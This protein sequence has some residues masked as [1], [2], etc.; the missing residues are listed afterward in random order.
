[1][2]AFAADFEPIAAIAA[3]GGP[4]NDEPG[5]RTP[6]RTPRSRTG[7][8]TRDG[9]PAR[10]LLRDVDDRVA[11]QVAFARR[12]RAERYASS[13]ASTCSARASASL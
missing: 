2:I 9:S 6:P 5:A 4:T 13:Q 10:R 7:S 11:G 12:R 3:G 8:R 1:M